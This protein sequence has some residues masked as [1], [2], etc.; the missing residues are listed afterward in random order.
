M[1]IFLTGASGLV[2]S[3]FARA[4]SLRRH[5]VVGVVG[6]FT[7]SCEASPND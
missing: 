4:A 5:H 3:T 2:G 7:A 6:A 1:K